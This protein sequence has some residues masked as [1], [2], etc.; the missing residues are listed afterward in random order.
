M[1]THVHT[2]T[3]I[4]TRTHYTC[5]VTIEHIFN[6]NYIHGHVFLIDNKVFFRHH[7]HTCTCT[8]KY[9]H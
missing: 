8:H 9:R 6:Y 2:H 1:Y 7:T 4:F 3:H 5:I